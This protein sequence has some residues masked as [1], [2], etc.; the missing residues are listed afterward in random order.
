MSLEDIV[1]RIDDHSVGIVTAIGVVFLIGV[2][3]WFGYCIW[4][5]DNTT[6]TII[7]HDGSKSYACEVCRGDQKPHECKPIK[8]DA[9]QETGNA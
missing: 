3:G 2:F 9:R 7:L 1:D 8:E 6:E 4:E 5:V